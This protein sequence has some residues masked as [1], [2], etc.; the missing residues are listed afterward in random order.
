MEPNVYFYQKLSRQFP[1]IFSV[2]PADAQF[3]LQ[4]YLQPSTTITENLTAVGCTKFK[5]RH[6]GNSC[7]KN[8]KVESY[9]EPHHTNLHCGCW[10]CSSATLFKVQIFTVGVESV[11]KRPLS[12][13]ELA[14]G[15]LKVSRKCY[16]ILFSFYLLFISFFFLELGLCLCFLKCVHNHVGVLCVCVFQVPVYEWTHLITEKEKLNFLKK[17][18]FFLSQ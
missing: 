2:Y 15:V 6:F 8:T 14:V 9:A 11:H 18:L 12:K 17:K 16:H 1:P 7:M 10:R 4:L 13:Y 3:F 5:L